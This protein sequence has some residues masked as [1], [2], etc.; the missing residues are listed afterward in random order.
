MKSN[1][2]IYGVKKLCAV[3]NIPRSTYY[4]KINPK[5][6]NREVEN[7]TIKKELLKLYKQS[8]GRYGAPKLHILLLRAGFKLSLKRTQ[9]LMCQLGL[10]SIIVKKFKPTSTKK[11]IE[12]LENVLNRDFTTSNINEKW[13]GDITYIKT[14]LHGWCY[15]ASVLDL[16]SKKIVGYSFGKNMTNDLV[17]KALKNAYYVQSPN[18]DSNII[19]HTDL[20]S[21]YTSKEMKDLCKELNITQSF[22]KKGCPYDNACIESFHAIIKKEEVYRNIYKTYEDAKLAIFSYIE[23]WYNNKRLHSAINYRTPNEFEILAKNTV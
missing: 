20:G 6:S 17:V 8:K 19:F 18:K 1:K 15:L 21:Q 4:S 11:P 23:G 3:L 16:H 14:Q 13:V 7:T 22:S 9:R 2:N 5:K 10:K 12:G